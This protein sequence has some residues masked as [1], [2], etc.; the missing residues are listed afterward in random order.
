MDCLRNYRD[1]MKLIID[2]HYFDDK[3]RIAGG[4]SGKEIII[5]I[6]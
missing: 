3:A 1:S 6:K 2:V 5:Y 4:L